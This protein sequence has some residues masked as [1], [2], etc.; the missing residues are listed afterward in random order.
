MSNYLLDDSSN[1]LTDG[2]GNRLV[3]DLGGA[4]SVLASAGSFTFSG[5]AA[6][7]TER[8]V[9]VLRLRYRKF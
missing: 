9:M 4:A 5:F 8:A 6:A 3:A 2:S 1:F 7:L